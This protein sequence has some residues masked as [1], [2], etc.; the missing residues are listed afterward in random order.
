MHGVLYDVL[1]RYDSDESDALHEHPF[2]KPYTLAPA[3]YDKQQRQLA[4]FLINALTDTVAH[5]IHSAFQQVY[6]YQTEL[7][8]GRI[9]AT[10]AELFILNTTSFEQ[11]SHS[12]PLRHVSL[13]FLTPTAFSQGHGTLALPLPRNV[14]QRPFDV[15]QSFAP[16][17]Y[18][19]PGDWLDWCDAN[20][21]VTRHD[22]RTAAYHVNRAK[23]FY[24][25][26]GS[27]TFSVRAR[28]DADPQ[29]VAI[30]SQTLH[31]LARFANFSHVGMKT[32]M[33]MGAVELIDTD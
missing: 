21:F 32:T 8:F 16:E 4:G 19:L 1:R 25:F 33:G 23:R 22:I 28:R 18:Q 12:P 20:V 3:H 10:V 9:P 2:P 14:W 31:A 6:D 5:T 17:A 30:Y 11:L 15:W 7:H 24:G 29:I 13:R 26:T 27:V